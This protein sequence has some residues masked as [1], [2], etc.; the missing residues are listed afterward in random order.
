MSR[1]PRSEVLIA[2]RRRSG[3]VA[4]ED[5][6]PSS[7]PPPPP[8]QPQVPNFPPVYKGGS[9]SLPRTHN[10]PANQNIAA[11]TNKAATTAVG[12]KVSRMKEIFQ[13]ANGSPAGHEEHKFQPVKTYHHQVARSPPPALM[14]RSPTHLASQSKTHTSAPRTTDPTTE[15]QAVS[16][17][18]LSTIDYLIIAED[19]MIEGLF[20]IN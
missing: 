11:N 16:Y 2:S 18:S 8:E 6:P 14:P 19:W 13:T 3:S 1:N 4:M 15:T 10:K 9:D 17:T 20:S 7:P 12:S 5:L